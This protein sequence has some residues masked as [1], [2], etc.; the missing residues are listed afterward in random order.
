[1]LK[2][3]GTF[4]SDGTKRFKKVKGRILYDELNNEEYVIDENGKEIDR[5]EE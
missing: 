3:D 2:W 1:M 5:K 4:N